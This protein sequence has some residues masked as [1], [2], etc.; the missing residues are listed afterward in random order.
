MGQQVAQDTQQDSELQAKHTGERDRGAPSTGRAGSPVQSPF[1]F[2][3]P[4]HWTG[5][6][7]P[8]AT[9]SRLQAARLATFKS[10]PPTPIP[11][12]ACVFLLI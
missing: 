8:G 2:L 4:G 1:C 11:P 7:T 10:I 5:S 12:A 9:A 6:G 3:V